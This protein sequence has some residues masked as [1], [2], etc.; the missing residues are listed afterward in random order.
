M[1]NIYIYILLDLVTNVKLYDCPN[2]LDNFSIGHKSPIKSKF[3][4][5]VA[6]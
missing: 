2:H 5:Y 6:S 4:S 1:N 3:F